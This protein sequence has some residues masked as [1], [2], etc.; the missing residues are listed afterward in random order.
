MWKHTGS[1]LWERLFTA[2]TAIWGSA[3]VAHPPVLCFVIA[4]SLDVIGGTKNVFD[5]WGKAE[6]DAFVL[7]FWICQPF[8]L[9]K[10]MSKISENS[11]EKLQPDLFSVELW[12]NPPVLLEE[13]EAGCKVGIYKS[14]II[15]VF[16][17]LYF[18]L[19][20]HGATWHVQKIRKERW[21]EMNTWL[22]LLLRQGENHSPKTQESSRKKYI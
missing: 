18:I 6:F 2:S 5:G 8:C 20:P 22:E 19:E 15:S 9:L 17:P 1:C 7:F 21:E 11:P 4:R 12:P 13:R 3:G 14:H 16:R 10:K